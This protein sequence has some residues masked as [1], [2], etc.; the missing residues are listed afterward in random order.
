MLVATCW[1]MARPAYDRS[2]TLEFFVRQARPLK[3]LQMN[4]FFISGALLLAASSLSFFDHPAEGRPMLQFVA[5]FGVLGGGF[6]I[7]LFQRV[8]AL[9]EIIKRSL[10]EVYSEIGEGTVSPGARADAQN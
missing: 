6:I 1:G 7:Q 2:L 8:F 5:S 3:K 10:P 9:E 4:L